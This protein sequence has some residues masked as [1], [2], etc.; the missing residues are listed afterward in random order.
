MLTTFSTLIKVKW[1]SDPMRWCLK[2]K[3]FLKCYCYYLFNITVIIIWQ[4][5]LCKISFSNFKYLDLESG[6]QLILTKIIKEKTADL[7]SNPRVGGGCIYY[8]I[9]QYYN[10]CISDSLFFPW[11]ALALWKYWFRLLKYLSIIIWSVG[12]I[13]E[14]DISKSSELT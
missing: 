5:W 10:L 4:L 11:I 6:Q 12:K 7:C 8:R 13:S 9:C 14:K 3:L 2:D 1:V